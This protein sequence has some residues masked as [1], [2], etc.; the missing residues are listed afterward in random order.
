MNQPLPSLS[1]FLQNI[2]T[3]K[4]SCCLVLTHLLWYHITIAAAALT[5]SL[6]RRPHT[7]LI[8]LSATL[9]FRRGKPSTLQGIISISWIL[10]LRGHCIFPWPFYLWSHRVNQADFALGSHFFWQLAA[11]TTR[12]KKN[13]LHSFSAFPS[14]AESRAGLRL[15]PPKTALLLLP[16]HRAACCSPSDIALML[17]SP[18][19]IWVQASCQA[20]E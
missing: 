7:D 11:F 14:T 8:S 19:T 4:S 10:Q 9:P 20:R 12:P 2:S 6:G 15:I 18:D 3:S 1:S 16:C 13:S 17:I 5:S